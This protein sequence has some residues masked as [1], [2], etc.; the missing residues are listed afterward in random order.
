MRSPS[1][2]QF[3]LV[4][5]LLMTCIL[6]S[7]A[8][9]WDQSVLRAEAKPEEAFTKVTFRYKYIAADREK[10]PKLGPL[11]RGVTLLP[12]SIETSTDVSGKEATQLFDLQIPV[13]C[14]AGDHTIALPLIEPPASEPNE[15]K[16]TLK[17]PEFVDI[18]PRRLIW[19]KGG[20]HEPQTTSIVSVTPEGVTF[21]QLALSNDA[22]DATLERQAAQLY[23]VK[24]SP[25]TTN[26]SVLTVVR[27]IGADL[28][29]KET[30]FNL[31]AEVQ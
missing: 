15:L 31:Y 24:I 28:H 10:L 25:K 29:G 4:W 22:F 12:G 18:K 2:R 6:L 30:S 1:I 17:V 19:E 5:I 20:A 21:T 8:G 9:Q 11:P 16:V 27:V 13:G 26:N 3:T 14:V 23:T 7:H